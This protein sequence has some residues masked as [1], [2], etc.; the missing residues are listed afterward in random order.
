MHKKQISNLKQIMP[1]IWSPS[2]N[3]ESI[4]SDLENLDENGNIE[5]WISSLPYPLAS[6]ART[7]ETSKQDHLKGYGLLKDF[8]KL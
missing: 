3:I 4:L 2:E 1:M 5:S 7:W 6:I 8:S